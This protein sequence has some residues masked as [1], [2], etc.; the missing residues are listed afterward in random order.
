[1]K[2]AF[3]SDG[4]GLESMLAHH[5]GRCRYY[6][7]ADLENGKVKSVETK[8][9]PFFSSHEPGVVPQFIARENADVI[10]AGGM[11]P[12]AIDWFKQLGVQAATSPS[13]KISDVLDDFLAGKFQN[14]VPCDDDDHSH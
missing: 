8:Q 1:M 12:R 3:A 14:A 11:G 9:N 10:I 6:V 7:F 13:K 4:E 2:I 5:F